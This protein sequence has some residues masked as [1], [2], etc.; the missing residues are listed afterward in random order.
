[1]AF[2]WCIRAG[3]RAPSFGL[4]VRLSLA[5]ITCTF[6][7]DVEA[8]SVERHCQQA[9]INTLRTP[10]N[11]RVRRTPRFCYAGT[12]EKAYPRNRLTAKALVDAGA[13][14]EHAHVPVWERMPDKS[15]VGPGQLA[16]MAGLLAFTYGRLVPE[17]ALRLLRCDALVIG[18]IGQL[19]MLILGPVAKLSR[20]PVVFDP[21]ITL[22]DT[23]VEDRG[24]VSPR[25]P[26]ARLIGLIDRAAL[27]LADIVLADT[28]ENARYVS[29]RFGVPAERIVV[30]PVGADD[31]IFHQGVDGCGDWNDATPTRPLDVL[32]YGKFIPLHGIE[33][34][35]RAAGII[36]QIAM[37]VRFEVIGTGQTYEQMRDL[38]NQLNVRTITWTDWLPYE[39]LGDRLGKAD[40]ALG[41]FSGG[42]KAGRVVPNK[43][44]QSLAAGVATVTRES[45]AI[46][47]F[48]ADDDSAILV[49]PD[50][51]GVLADA[52][53][54][55]CSGE[56][57]KRIANAGT[58]AYKRNADC[59]ART[60]ILESVIE[61]VMGNTWQ[62]QPT[63][64]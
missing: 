30:L 44:Y 9:I 25:S 48:L 33:T 46:S 6:Q 17:M 3:F 49:L 53:Q 16:R 57:R 22:T 47:N 19:D 5:H 28:A 29:E 1:M 7:I 62:R 50:D 38:A 34:I 42:A 10:Y 8:T 64:G 18:Y 13:R 36:E 63:H 51:P 55:L 21:L 45:P 43:V 12:Y 27:Q 52:L 32:F 31:T 61:R 56:R 14:V 26:V 39:D 59:V 41:I 15:R 4:H 2:A 35:V 54:Q 37:P 60:T 40:V 11:S 58:A 20:K 24:L 23:I